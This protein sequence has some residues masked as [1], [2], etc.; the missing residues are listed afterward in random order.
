MMK[1]II[2]GS[3]NIQNKKLIFETLDKYKD[4]IT[5]VVCGEAT[6][7][8]II[9]KEWGLKNNIPIKSFPA[10]WDKYGRMAGPIRNMDMGDYAD[11]LIA[12]WDGQSVGTKHMFTYM[13]Q[14]GKHGK[15]VIMK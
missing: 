15:V 13:Q 2:A 8:D 14:I 3:R 4:K 11:Y 1:I 9:G 10:E 7:V 5:E 12:F 6:G